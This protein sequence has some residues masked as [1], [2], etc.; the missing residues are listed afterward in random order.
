M[1][2]EDKRALYFERM[3]KIIKE[4]GWMVQAVFPTTDDPD[5]YSFQYTIGLHDRALP[6]LVSTGLPG[7]VGHALLNEVVGVVTK[8][9]EA[10]LPLLGKIEVEDWSTSFYLLPADPDRAQELATAARNRSQGQAAYLQVCWPSQD[11]LFPWE[12]GASDEYR[13][14]QPLLGNPVFYN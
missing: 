2:T 1:M 7:E 5:Q 11:G 10:G 9:I 14:A 6:E 13:Q 8:R 3:E 12:P 4:H